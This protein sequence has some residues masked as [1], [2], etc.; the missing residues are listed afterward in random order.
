MRNDF[1]I[2]CLIITKLRIQKHLFSFTIIK[3]MLIYNHGK[4]SFPH[5]KSTGFTLF[6]FFFMFMK[7]YPKI[8]YK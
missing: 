7:Y 1:N 2:F 6:S 4:Y 8:F 3:I 5:E